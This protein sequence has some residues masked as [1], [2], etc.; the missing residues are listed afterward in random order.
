MGYLPRG[1][2]RGFFK[3]DMIGL[4]GALFKRWKLERNEGLEV[5]LKGNEGSRA[6]S[7]G[8][9]VENALPLM[10]EGSKAHSKRNEVRARRRTQKEV[11]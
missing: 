4:E 10:V 5:C 6:H 7:K 1:K 3:S 9:R 8:G 11:G 2:I